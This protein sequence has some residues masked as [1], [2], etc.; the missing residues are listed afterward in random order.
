M[1]TITADTW[2][3]VRDMW[4]RALSTSLAVSVA[5]V[6]EDGAPHVS[7][8]GSLTLGREPG[9]GSMLELFSR[10][11]V[12]NLDRDPRFIVLA[13]DSSALRFVAALARGRFP[14]AVATRLSGTAEPRR[15]ATDEEV[16]RFRRRVRAVRRLKGHDLLWGAGRIRA[17]DLVFDLELPVH[18]G[19]MTAHLRRPASPAASG[20]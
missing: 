8:I 10:Q 5:T 16:A 12:R 11:M 4:N 13:V 3:E 1:P 7:P 6:N 2:P 15:W 20:P 18:L 17:R 19:P 14:R 9:T